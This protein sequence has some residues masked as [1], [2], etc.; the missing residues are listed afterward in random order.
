MRRIIFSLL[1]A[2]L[3]VL[4]TIWIPTYS[5][6]ALLSKR[7]RALVATV[8]AQSAPTISSISPTQT[9]KGT[10]PTKIVIKGTG[11]QSGDVVKFN[12]TAVSAKIKSATKIA[13]KN[14]A[15]SLFQTDVT[16][17]VTI[18]SSSGQSSNSLDFIVGT[19]SQTNTGEP[20]SI[21]IT[22]PTSFVLNTP[23]ALTSN[24]VA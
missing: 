19:G 21:V 4:T 13:I 16:Y 2:Y 5:H 1:F 12:D 3:I 23:N 22:S 9:A 6:T 15:A 17:K 11:F 7:N 8:R 24:T 18:T 20:A 10:A 14:A